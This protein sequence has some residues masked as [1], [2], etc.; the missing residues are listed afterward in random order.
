MKEYFKY[1]N[2]F[3][4]INDENLFLTTTGNWSETINLVEKSAKSIKQN[5]FKLN[6]MHIYY[7][8]AILLIG[9][10][11]FDI[12]KDVKTSTFPF[13]II[14]LA[15]AGFAYLKREK[16]NRYKIPISKIK[17]IEFNSNSAK[18]IFLNINN[19]LDFEEITGVDSK[20]LIILSKFES[21]K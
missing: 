3:V 5:N 15:L 13:G 14:L 2:G 8:L 16:G 1:A 19:T 11:S 20:G 9:F 21:N 18:I 4:N 10:I 7:F 6:K 12:F 17:T